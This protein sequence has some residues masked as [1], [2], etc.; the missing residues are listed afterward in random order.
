MKIHIIDKYYMTS[1][2]FNFILNVEDAV[3]EGENAGTLRTRPIGFYSRVCDLVEAVIDLKMKSSTTQSMKGFIQEH[4]ALVAEIR[5]LFQ[6]GIKGEFILEQYTGLKDG[7]N[8]DGVEIYAGSRVKKHIKD[9]K[10]TE[11]IEVTWLEH[12]CGF[13]I[14]K[15]S[16]HWYETI[17]NIHDKEQP[18][19]DA[20]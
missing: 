3:K 4:A 7:K 15:G 6:V 14:K 12:Q 9:N 8:Y 17:G 20:S 5:Q 1:D 16:N 2:A 11:T 10:R 13:N 19:Q 18:C